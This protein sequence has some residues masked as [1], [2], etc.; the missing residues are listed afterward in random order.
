MSSNALSFTPSPTGQ[1]DSPLTAR[2]QEQALALSHV[3]RQRAFGKCYSS[4]LGRALSTLNII[5][6]GSAD[7][8]RAESYVHHSQP[9]PLSGTP[10]TVNSPPSVKPSLLVA[11]AP[12]ASLLSSSR[13]LLS[14]SPYP[15]LLPSFF[16]QTLDTSSPST[17]SVPSPAPLPHDSLISPHLPPL[18]LP[19]EAP[20]TVHLTPLL[21]ERSAGAFEGQPRSAQLRASPQA[22]QGCENDDDVSLRAHL[23]L[24]M[25]LAS[26]ASDV[27]VVSHGGWIS[28]F[29]RRIAFCFVQ[30]T[31]P[32]ASMSLVRVL[33]NEY[34]E[35][36]VRALVVGDV[37]HLQRQQSVDGVRREWTDAREDDASA[38]ADKEQNTKKKQQGPR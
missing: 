22:R 29:L 24:D 13:P 27:L 35:R 8:P 12:S 20:H 14:P 3:L 38:Y 10:S 7:L 30:H 37:S 31:V 32:N 15:S 33:E 16:E 2:G 4:D 23:F 25:V 28:C 36:E 17:S 34:G 6:S 18:L 11:T 9:T 19:M 21:R 5:L 1:T 26:S